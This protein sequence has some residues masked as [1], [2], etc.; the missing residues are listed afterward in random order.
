MYGLINGDGPEFLFQTSNG[1]IY[2]RK[3]K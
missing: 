1:N 3:A 2:I